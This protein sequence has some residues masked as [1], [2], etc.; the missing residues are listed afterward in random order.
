M[1]AARRHTAA[2]LVAAIAAAPQRFEFRQAVRLVE[3]ALNELDRARGAEPRRPVGLDHAPQREAL[4][5]KAAASLAHP[6][7]AL[8]DSR[9]GREGAP[10]EG[11][12]ELQA[13]CFGLV[14]AVGVLPLHY[15][16]LVLRRE[17]L[18]DTSL[19]DFLD[20]FHHRAL[21]LFHRASRK[22]ALGLA[23]E[24]GALFGAGPDDFSAALQSFAG[25]SPTRRAHS[26]T[27]R[28][29]L[30]F[31]GHFSDQRRSQ[32]ALEGLLSEQL[33]AP[34]QVRQFVGQWLH[35]DPDECS[36]LSARR[37]DDGVAQRLGGGFVL[38]ARVW[39]VVSRIAI[40]VGPLDRERLRSLRPDGR[41]LR[42]LAQLV[43]DFSQGSCDAVLECLV[44]P[45][46]APALRLG[47]ARSSA[48]RLGWDT[49][50]RAQPATEP[51]LVR[52][53]LERL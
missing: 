2:G 7:T 39:D 8:R 46:A 18:K 50:L 1:E 31:A 47:G 17:H 9:R 42:E 25:L 40:R 36:R 34:V 28:A 20:V 35:L 12:L 53:H 11:A 4:R 49:W 22:Y 44:R 48:T 3:R 45:D 32:L 38:G 41:L 16:E 27:E 10:V 30:E 26:L 52:L 33:E 15:T 6:H 43:R 14:G 29:R 24:H 5:L 51:A 37:R 13:Q 21:S 19:R 23:Y